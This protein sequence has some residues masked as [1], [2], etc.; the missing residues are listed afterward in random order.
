[1][2]ARPVTVR[3]M[4]TN[5]EIIRVVREQFADGEPFTVSTAR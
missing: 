3:T 2:A 5:E 1:M 4:D